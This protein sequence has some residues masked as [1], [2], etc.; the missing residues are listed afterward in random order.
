MDPVERLRQQLNV[1]TSDFHRVVSA[2]TSLHTRNEE[3][4]DELKTKVSGLEAQLHGIDK[5]LA[6]LSARH[7]MLQQPTR[8]DLTPLGIPLHHHQHPQ[9]T[10]APTAPAAP[11]ERDS[12]PEIGTWLLHT[13][14]IVSKWGPLIVSAVAF[15]WAGIRDCGIVNVQET[16]SNTVITVPGHMP[17]DRQTQTNSAPR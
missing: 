10:A 1:F 13:K 11:K 8:A 3:D 16:P 7:D 17:H 6:V 15:A 9:P 12:T 5:Q 2:L 4:I 14:A